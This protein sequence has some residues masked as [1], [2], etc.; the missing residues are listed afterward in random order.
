V[1][2]ECTDLSSN[3]YECDGILIPIWFECDVEEPCPNPFNPDCGTGGPTVCYDYNTND[4]IYYNASALGASVIVDYDDPAAGG[5]YSYGNVA[6]LCE[7]PDSLQLCVYLVTSGGEETKLTYLSDFTINETTAVVVLDSSLSVG[8]FTKVRLARC[9]DDSKMVLTFTEGAKLSAEDVNTSLHQ[10]L[11]L[12][13]EKE[14]GSNTYYQ[15]E[16]ASSTGASMTMLCTS[17]T[18]VDYDGYYFNLTSYEAAGNT[19]ITYRFD[20]AGV[21]ATG[22]LINTDEVCIQISAVTTIDD[23]TEE[24]ENAINDTTNGHNTKLDT[25]RSTTASELNDRLIIS[26]AV[27]GTAGNITSLGHSSELDT[28]LFG[29]VAVW[30]FTNGQDYDTTDP[31]I[32][33]SP[34]VSLPVNFDL[35][36]TRQNDV[37]SWD[38]NGSFIGKSPT[39]VADNI[40]LDNLSNLALTLVSEDDMLMFDGTDWVNK[41]FTTEVLGVINLIDYSDWVLYDT[42]ADGKLDDYYYTGG[43]CETDLDVAWGASSSCIT[44]LPKDL[45]P[46]AFTA[47][48]IGYY[49]AER[50][51]SDQILS[52]TSQLNTQIDSKITDAGSASGTILTS[53][54]WEMGRGEGRGVGMSGYLHMYPKAFMDVRD[55]DQL[56]M[57]DATK[58]NVAYYRYWAAVSPS[59]DNKLFKSN[60]TSFTYSGDKST[61]FGLEGHQLLDSVPTGAPVTDRYLGLLRKSINKTDWNSTLGYTSEEHPA[62]SVYRDHTDSMIFADYQYTTVDVTAVESSGNNQNGENVWESTKNLPSVVTYYLGQLW[63]GAGDIPSILE[64]EG[65]PYHGGDLG[66]SNDAD[67]LTTGILSDPAPTYLGTSGNH[68]FF[69]KWFVTGKDTSGTGS[70]TDEG[71]YD[72]LSYYNPFEQ[73]LLNKDADA[74]FTVLPAEPSPTDSPAGQEASFE[75]GGYSFLINA[76]KV[77]STL[78]DYMIPDMHDEYVFSV[79]FADA[80]KVTTASCEDAQCYEVMASIDQYVDGCADGETNCSQVGNVDLSGSSGNANGYHVYPTDFDAEVVK[81][82]DSYPYDKLSIDVR[83]KTGSGFDLVLKVP[84]FKRVGKISVWSDE[85]GGVTDYRQLSLNWLVDN[86][87]GDWDNAAALNPENT[88]DSYA[89]PPN[90]TDMTVSSPAAFDVETAVQY[91]RMGVPSNV[92]ISFYTISTPQDNVFSDS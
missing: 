92:R 17:S 35:S 53:L 91:I 10:L 50:Q 46:N 78:T 22:D 88:T 32:T 65:N 87:P 40:Q 76:N 36:L 54:R 21:I 19:T 42:A 3:C 63:D 44:N 18:L 47:F 11:F 90:L 52:G 61:T 13:Q 66:Q 31:I 39:D 43:S 75:G 37:L 27:V 23:M 45:V 73:L 84:R 89:G 62:S 70:T 15:V 81:I 67:S 16:N 86:I 55:F 79:V 59:P 82:W 9:T 5:S 83:N 69:W 51:I 30:G 34:P 25:A 26:Q 77:F 33:F 8:G 28:P 85:S 14:F 41:D 7:V 6:T 4:P 60:I 64:W 74:E 57:T 20:D 12:I 29:G 1:P 2:P 58:T 38:G 56:D 49:A 48:G 24:I 68:Y 72:E 71:V 80:G